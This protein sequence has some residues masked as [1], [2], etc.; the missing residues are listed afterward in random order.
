MTEPIKILCIEN[1]EY[2]LKM[3]DNS[4]H[5]DITAFH[6]NTFQGVNILDKSE[7]WYYPHY[8]FSKDKTYKRAEYLINYPCLVINNHGFRLKS[9]H[10]DMPRTS[11]QN[12]TIPNYDPLPDRM[13]IELAR[14]EMLGYERANDTIKRFK[15]SY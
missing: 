9:Y 3:V 8:L 14:D 13:Y 15:P 5:L 6:K 2:V 4:Y 7:S 12:P 11:A 1:G 10:S